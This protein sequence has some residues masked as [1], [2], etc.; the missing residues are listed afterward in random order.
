[1]HILDNLNLSRKIGLDH[2]AKVPRKGFSL[3]SERNSN[4]SISKLNSSN[5]FSVDSICTLLLAANLTFFYNI[6]SRLSTGPTSLACYNV[7]V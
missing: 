7:E 1:M 2:S 5:S 4:T 3:T 6:Y